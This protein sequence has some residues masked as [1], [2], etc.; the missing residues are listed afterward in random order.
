MINKIA[1]AKD[2]FP[3]EYI[4]NCPITNI[5]RYM[6]YFSHY[7]CRDCYNSRIVKK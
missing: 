6:L 1:I 7:E 3:L 4:E 2:G 5:I